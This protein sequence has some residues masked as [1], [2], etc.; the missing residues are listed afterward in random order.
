MSYN[1]F[2]TSTDSGLVCEIYKFQIGSSLYYYTSS[3]YDVTFES[4]VYTSTQINRSKIKQSSNAMKDGITINLPLSHDFSQFVLNPDN[5]E[6]ITISIYRGHAND[7][8]NEF[9]C[10]W[11]GR[12]TGHT[13]NGQNFSMTCE[14]VFTSIK[15]VGLRARFELSCRHALYDSKCGVSASAFEELATINT[16]NG[17]TLTFTGAQAFGD[18]YFTG[19]FIKDS[20]GI[21]RFIASHI[22]DEI[23]LFRR[24]PSIVPG[25]IVR[26]FPGCNRSI[27]NCKNK[28]NNL[29]NHGGFPFIPSKNPFK[30]VSTW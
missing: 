29:D 7:P 4:Q 11:L 18:N 17:T 15:S 8:D 1:A 12:V 23:R 9:I 3:A 2:D 30:F 5:V 6:S 27:D 25:S 24:V 22:G 20:N 19:G 10:Y 16:V 13:V 26:I 28:F 21:S 14:S